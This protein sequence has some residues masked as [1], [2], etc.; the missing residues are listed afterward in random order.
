M[1]APDYEV[2]LAAEDIV[3]GSKFGVTE[4]LQFD[5]FPDVRDGQSQF[6]E[7]VAV[8][9][10]EVLVVVGVKLPQVEDEVLSI[11]NGSSGGQEFK[12]EGRF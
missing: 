3:V 12:L 1:S 8:E 10:A 7:Y 4:R 2:D 9:L 6:V 5:R 11:P